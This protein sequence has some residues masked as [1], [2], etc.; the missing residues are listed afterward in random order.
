LS[1]LLLGGVVAIFTSSK[2]T[3]E[4]VERLSRIQENGRFALDA[5]VRDVRSAG[6][7][8]CARPSTFANTLSNAAS[9]AWDFEDAIFGY[10][11]QSGT[12]WSPS[13]PADMTNIASGTANASDAIVLRVPAWMN[14]SAPLRLID[15][16]TSQT[17][18][19][20]IAAV[21]ASDPA[22]IEVNQVLMLAD[23]HARAVF[24]VTGYNKT[25]GIVTHAASAGTSTSPG[26]ASADLGH[27]FEAN[28]Q[29]VRLQTVA[30]YIGSSGGRV[31]LWRIV[32]GGT[33]EELIEGVER[34]ELRF[35]QDTNG[36]R[37]ADSYAS[38]NSV[39]NWDNVVNVSVAMLVRSQEQYGTERDAK[40][41]QLL[42][43][44]YTAPNDR[45]LRQVFVTTATL[46]NRAL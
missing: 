11:Y 33:P 5:V 45:H 6:Y 4:A 42:D 9:L 19:L 27:A 22:P 28:S 21:A 39:S 43:K 16:M 1:L 17:A 35:G 20:K 13:I 3:Y 36:D 12:T 18:D 23:C 14:T 38:A 25:T 32:G 26:N 34:M 31:G 30:Y 29:V 37:I 24:E 40:T 2:T 10:D 44:Q 46:R 15:K 8:G 7:I 41:Y